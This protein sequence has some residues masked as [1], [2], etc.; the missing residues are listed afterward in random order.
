MANRSLWP[1]GC[2]VHQKHLEYDTTE[3]IK[4]IVSRTGHVAKYG[5]VSGLTLSVDQ[6]DASRI[7]VATGGGYT[8]SGEYVELSSASQVQ[9]DRTD[10]V[11]SYI[12]LVYDESNESPE[13]HESDGTQKGTKA[14]A[15]ARL[16]VSTDTSSWPLTSPV[17]SV[18]AV[19]RAMLLGIVTGKGLLTSPVVT[20]PT[21]FGE[22]KYASQ[23]VNITGVSI[24][25]VSGDTGVGAGTLYYIVSSK[26]ELKW[27]APGESQAGAA[28]EIKNSDP[29]TL[30]SSTG[31]TLLL[32]VAFT[33]L[34]IGSVNDNIDVSNLYS[35]E[36]SR[37]SAVDA[38][39]R[40]LIGGGQPTS[41]NPHGMTMD[42]LAP[43]V[44]GS[45]EQHQD[46][47]HSNGIAP[48]SSAELFECVLGHSNA[49]PDTVTVKV[50]FAD[51]DAA[52]VNGRRIEYV[53]NSVSNTLGFTEVSVDRPSLYGIYLSQDKYVFK[54]LR[55]QH[56]DANLADR[57]YVINVSPN[58]Q[59]GSGS[60][61]WTSANKLSFSSGIEIDVSPGSM[62]GETRLVRLVGDDSVSY[63]DV[64]VKLGSYATATTG[65]AFSAEPDLTVNLPIA[66]VNYSGSTDDTVGYGFSTVKSVFDR[67]TYGTLMPQNLNTLAGYES[68]RD[69]LADTFSADSFLALPSA[70]GFTE[71]I[72]NA[73]NQLYYDDYWFN[74]R[75]S[76]GLNATFNGGTAYLLGKRFNVPTATLSLPQNSFSYVYVNKLGTIS[77]VS[78]ASSLAFNGELNRLAYSGD[79]EVGICI[80]R[81]NSSSLIATDDYRQYT[82]KRIGNDIRFGQVGLDGQNKAIIRSSNIGLPG[83]ALTVIGAGTSPALLVQPAS[84]SSTQYVARI[85]TLPSGPAPT[86]P[87]N[88]GGLYSSGSGDKA[89]VTAIATGSA[90]GV[91]A[92]SGTDAGVYGQ[93]GSPSGGHAPSDPLTY[94]KGAGIYGVGG[95]NVSF[96]VVGVGG[97]GDSTKLSGLDPSI[98]PASI[99]VIGVGSGGGEGIFG[100]AGATAGAGI[101]GYGGAS[102]SNA[103][104]V[105]GRGS[106]YGTWGVY[107]Y[108]GSGRVD[109]GGV[110][111]VGQAGANG[112]GSDGVHG[113]G[114][115]TRGRGGY[116]K[117]AGGVSNDSYAI[118]ADGQ[119]PIQ[120]ID[121]KR[122]FCSYGD[123]ENVSASNV[124]TSSNISNNWVTILME[125]V[126]T[127]DSGPLNKQTLKFTVLGHR[128]FA[129][130]YIEGYNTES[131]RLAIEWA[132]PLADWWM[133]TFVNARIAWKRNVD[134][135]TSQ[136][137]GDLWDNWPAWAVTMPQHPNDINSDQ[138]LQLERRKTT[139][140]AV[141]DGPRSMENLNNYG[142]ANGYVSLGLPGTIEQTLD[143]SLLISVMVYG[144]NE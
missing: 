63:V 125:Y 96:G 137:D 57:L 46:V 92:A 42:D 6:N 84:T 113:Y 22:A 43:G 1:E 45:L 95:T 73:S 118:V 14:I 3:R 86:P 140:I 53:V 23:P 19:D 71:G 82:Y 87:I 136:T 100:L 135:S 4:S 65:L 99:G 122:S 77:F 127:P 7:N 124:V 76:S 108:G 70:Y 32:D 138:A 120:L 109:T 27:K 34:P 39:H 68:V 26:K 141:A 101:H 10:G 107:G 106:T 47:M 60:I 51:G 18:N 81:T 21:V 93:G 104:G 62:G 132:K 117:A 114:G 58:M 20:S 61:T 28:T 17:L 110:K 102:S 143:Y 126:N 36:V 85:D 128:N 130:L 80:V 83:S 52:Y 69:V 79:P 64:L 9:V 112:A 134:S 49:Q 5:V 11:K 50:N 133:P 94:K 121:K 16:V 115:G 144:P 75:S 56:T 13:A 38:Q 31:K 35:Q 123:I 29:V 97:T 67:R 78:G 59:S 40:S 12:Y 98:T 25:S 74:L 33:R 88:Q 111:G 55:V 54:S 105:Y 24:I 131:S 116:F 15:T 142:R 30:E 72:S 89:A 37:F 90:P 8:P 129:N 41:N 119:A 66:Y 48:G 139:R 91:F 103:V 2:E 44:A